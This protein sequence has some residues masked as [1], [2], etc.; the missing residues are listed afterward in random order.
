MEST[1]T[2]IKSLDGKVGHFIASRK[3]GSRA[4]L[5]EDSSILWYKHEDF[6]TLLVTQKYTFNMEEINME[7]YR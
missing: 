2:E 1:L 7:D 3:D 4:V 5:W 6:P